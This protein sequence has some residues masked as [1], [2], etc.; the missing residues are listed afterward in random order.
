MRDE[1]YGDPISEYNGKPIYIDG[2]DTFYLYQYKNRLMK[3]RVHSTPC[4]WC[5]KPTWVDASN[6]KNHD[7]SFCS[8]ECFGE[9]NRGE[10]NCNW[11]EGLI[12]SGNGYPLKHKPDH[13]RARAGRVKEHILVAEDSLGRFLNAS[14]R[15][16]HIDCIKTNN[17]PDNLFVCKNTSEHNDIHNS[18]NDCVFDLMAAGVLVF[19]PEQKR[20]EVV[21]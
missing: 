15:V 4:S 13:P 11:V 10:N 1:K 17:D 12:L 14:E 19:N 21:Q 5:A 20:Y 9:S 7:R 16:H 2:T 6:F 3:R 8:K 18:L